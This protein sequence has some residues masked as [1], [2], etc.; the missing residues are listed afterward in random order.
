MGTPNARDDADKPAISMPM[1]ANFER[2]FVYL[3]ARA[4][5]A[6]GMPVTFPLISVLASGRE[7]GHIRRLQYLESLQA[8]VAIVIEA[9]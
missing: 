7:F 8:G 6:P 5:L 3:L 4:F 9:A 2:I 1:A